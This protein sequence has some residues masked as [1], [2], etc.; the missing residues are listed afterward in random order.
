[1][2]YNLG[3]CIKCTINTQGKLRTR[4]LYSPDLRDGLNYGL[5]IIRAGLFD[6]VNI[7]LIMVKP[8]SVM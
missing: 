5:V 7:S 1:M 6:L 8:I 2:E 4:N 3:L